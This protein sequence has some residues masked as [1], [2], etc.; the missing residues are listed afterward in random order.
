MNGKEWTKADDLFMKGLIGSFVIGIILVLVLALPGC[1][2]Q[3][4]EKASR[5]ANATTYGFMRLMQKGQTTRAQEQA[6][7][8]AMA[9]LSLQVDRE[10]RGTD[11]ANQTRTD[12]TAAIDGPST[13]IPAPAP[14]VPVPVP[15]PAP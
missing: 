6:F 9:A 7:I 13:A 12:A 4:M 5:E 15:T 11:K 2:K 3:Q 14:V 8:T 1:N 10:I